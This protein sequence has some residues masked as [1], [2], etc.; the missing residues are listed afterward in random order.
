MSNKYQNGTIQSQQQKKSMK[1]VK[2]SS[3][4]ASNTDKTYAIIPNNNNSHKTLTNSISFHGYVNHSTN[5]HHLSASNT[6]DNNNNKKNKNNNDKG[7]L[8]QVNAR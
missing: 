7:L 6:N 3:S 2:L 4:M 1:S 8:L 5:N